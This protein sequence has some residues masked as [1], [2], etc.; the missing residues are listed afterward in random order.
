MHDPLLAVF[1]LRAAQFQVAI[2]VVFQFV[3]APYQALRCVQ[4]GNADI[5]FMLRFAPCLG[6]QPPADD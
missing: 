2:G 5:F 6:S 3:A 4:A 1:L